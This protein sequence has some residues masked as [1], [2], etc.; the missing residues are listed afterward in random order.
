MKPQI[1]P[2]AVRVI[3]GQSLQAQADACGITRRNLDRLV[4][5]P[6][7][8]WRVET[9]ERWCEVCGL[10]FWDLQFTPAIMRRVNWGNPTEHIV[11]ALRAIHDIRNPGKPAPPRKVLVEIGQKAMEEFGCG[12]PT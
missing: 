10:S 2:Q 4:Q 5:L 7:K 11:R 3:C 1:P 9:A 12:N 8:K 6:W